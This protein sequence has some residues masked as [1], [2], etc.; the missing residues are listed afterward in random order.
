MPK[1]KKSDIGRRTKVTK[2]KVNEREAAATNS[3]QET[4]EEIEARL[5]AE[6]H[7]PDSNEQTQQTL[8][9][10]NAFPLTDNNEQIQH[11]NAFPLTENNE[12]TQKTLSFMQNPPFSK[13]T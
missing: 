13:I 11:R 7:L 1:R 9:N 10:N 5:N 12:Q 4:E 2:R 6:L 8:Q 3:R